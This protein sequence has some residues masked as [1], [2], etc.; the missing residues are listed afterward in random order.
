MQGRIIKGVGGFYEIEAGGRLYTCRARGK[1]RREGLTP[2]PGDFVEF[3]P[4]EGEELGFVGII[5]PRRNALKRPAVAN[6]DTLVLVTSARDPEP[7]LILLDKLLLSA[8]TLGVDIHLVINKCDLSP[9]DAVAAVA[10]QYASAVASVLPMS[11]AN[12]LGRDELLTRL[13]GRCSCL[14]GQSGVGK[15][16][17]LNSLFPERE[18]AT[19]ELSEKTARGRHTTRHVE[20]LPIP[21]GGDVADTP[22]FSLLEVEPMEP[23][24]L[25]GLYPEFTAYGGQCRFNGCLHDSE[26]GC[27]VKD[28]VREGKIPAGRWERYR[29]ILKE[30]KETWRNR[31]D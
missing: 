5:L 16:S 23:A 9:P 12:G 31:Y 1:F 19:G 29:E 17:I 14:A 8:R 13:A 7:D 28:A 18:L 2:L 21:G 3:S 25:P 10:V 27:A 26:P 20:L 24:D 4:G 15:S 11:A 6:V 22:G 30:T